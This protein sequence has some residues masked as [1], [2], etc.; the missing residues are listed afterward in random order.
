LDEKV[1]AELMKSIEEVMGT[2]PEGEGDELGKR[3][4]P[5]KIPVK[6]M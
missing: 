3:V 1:M 6:D 4:S 5:I 2:L